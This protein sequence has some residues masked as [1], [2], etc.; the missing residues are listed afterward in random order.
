MEIIHVFARNGNKLAGLIGEQ[1]NEEQSTNG[2]QMAAPTPE[3]H[4]LRFPDNTIERRRAQ[5]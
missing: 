4:S 3:A 1:L 2:T 5:D